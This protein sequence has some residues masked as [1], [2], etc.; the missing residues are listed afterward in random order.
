MCLKKNHDLTKTIDKK[1]KT[2]NEY[3]GL[4]TRDLFDLQLVTI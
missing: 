3:I 2:T 1:I 4:S